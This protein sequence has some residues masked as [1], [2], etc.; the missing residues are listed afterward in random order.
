[1]PKPLVIAHRGDPSRA[2][3]NSLEALRLALDVPADMIEIDLRKSRDNNLFLMHDERT[4]RT[5]DRDLLLESSVSDEIAA[6]HLRNREPVPTL[7]SVLSLVEGRSALNLEIK[8]VG[9]GA[10]AAAQIIGSAYRGKIVISSFHEREVSDAR[11]IMPDALAGQIF[12]AFTLADLPAYR[13]KGFGLVSIRR[14]AVTRELVAACHERNIK[15]FVWTVDN[16][17]EMKRFAEWGVDGIYSNK[18]GLLRQVVDE[19]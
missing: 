4:G 14:K 6:V 17:E 3:E 12:D 11:R 9:A 10:L 18:P 8:S 2:L 7:G 13:I 15:V 19:V 16:A 5:C 1:M